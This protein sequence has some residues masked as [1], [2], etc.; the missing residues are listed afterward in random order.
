M[1]VANDVG[2][3]DAGFAV[4]TNRVTM[5]A[6]DGSTETLP[7][8]SKAAVAQRVVE[9]V[10]ERLMGEWVQGKAVTLPVRR[11]SAQD[12]NLRKAA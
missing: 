8:M 10:A 1:I 3:T 5:L 4:D 2:A 6:D 11:R 7:L 9:R 12:A